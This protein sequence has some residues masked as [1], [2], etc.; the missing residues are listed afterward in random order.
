MFEPNAASILKRFR[1]FLRTFTNDRGEAVYVQRMEKMVMGA[2]PALA[3]RAS[4]PHRRLPAH[5]TRLPAGGLASR[6]PAD[7]P[8]CPASVARPVGRRPPPRAP[9]ALT[10]PALRGAAAHRSSTTAAP[11]PAGNGQSL[12]VDFRDLIAVEKCNIIA[13]WVADAPRQMLGLLNEAAG[14]VR[15]PPPPLRLPAPSFRAPG[16]SLPPRS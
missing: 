4:A 6:S 9:R 12:E 5:A 10:Q 16:S 14:Q 1:R 8:G 2:C 11:S 3:R 13:V 7:P 15:T